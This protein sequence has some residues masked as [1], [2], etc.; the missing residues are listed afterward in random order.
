MQ[1][2]HRQP[3]FELER[4]APGIIRRTV[5]Y[6]QEFP[7]VNLSGGALDKGFKRSAE[8]LRPIAST[9]H[10]AERM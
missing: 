8:T 4:D 2:P 6:N 5:V 1:D 3:I 9:N 7:P 10:K